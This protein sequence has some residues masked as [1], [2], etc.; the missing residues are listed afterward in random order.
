MTSGEYENPLTLSWMGDLWVIQSFSS[1]THTHTF[2][3]INCFGNLETIG[4]IA[5]LHL[6][7]SDNREELKLQ[8]QK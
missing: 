8:K 1:H 6:S 2:Q 3:T 4:D 7:L 5:L